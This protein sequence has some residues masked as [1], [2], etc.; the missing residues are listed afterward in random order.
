MYAEGVRGSTMSVV[1]SKVYSI[2]L[3]KLSIYTCFCWQQ[4]VLV[5][6]ANNVLFLGSHRVPPVSIASSLSPRDNERAPQR[7]APRHRGHQYRLRLFKV[8]A[9]MQP[10]KKHQPSKLIMLSQERQQRHACA[11]LLALRI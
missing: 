9:E 6:T 7:R 3:D 2:P 10:S 5:N 1:Q 4:A 11:C 8:G